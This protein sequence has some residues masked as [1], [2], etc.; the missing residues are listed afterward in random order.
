[1]LIFDLLSSQTLASFEG[2]EKGCSRKVS[3][4]T[5]FKKTVEHVS[6]NALTCMKEF[7]GCST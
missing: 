7:L 1:V 5:L 6:K 2:K 4:E 3:L